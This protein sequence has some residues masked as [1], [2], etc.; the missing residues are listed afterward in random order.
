MAWLGKWKF[1]PLLFAAFPALSF[2][3]RNIGEVG[4]VDVVRPLAASLVMGLLIF[5]AMWLILRDIGR[6]ALA[7]SLVT[8]LALSYGH[9]YG[10]LKSIGLSG[11]YLVRHRYL[12]PAVLCVA[13]LGVLAASRIRSSRSWTG[14]MAAVAAV[15]LLGPALQI[16]GYYVPLGL[17]SLGIQARTGDC[18]LPPGSAKPDVYLIILDAYEREDVLRDV[19]GYDN[20][21]FLHEL[22]ALGFYVAPGSLS[23]YN[24]TRL[25][26]ASLL[27]LNYVQDFPDL[28]GTGPSLLW[29]MSKKISDSEL[30]HELECLG[31]RTVA[32][33]T[34]IIWTEWSDAD[35]FIQE[36]EDV[37]LLRPITR[38]ELLFANTTWLRAMLDAGEQGTEGGGT[39]R[40]DPRQEHRDRVLFVLDELA[41]VAELPSP[42]FVFA[43]IVSPHP[44]Y[45]FGA[46]GED[47]LQGQLETEPAEDTGDAYARQVAYLN[48]RVL[49]LLRAIL[50]DSETPP[51]IVLMGDHGRADETPET[52]LSIL[53]AYFLPEGVEGLYPTITPVNTFRLILDHIFGA[54][55]GLLP[56]RSYYSRGDTPYEFTPVP[57]T[58]SEETGLLIAP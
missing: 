5:G 39:P 49:E 25:S 24:R 35:T 18:S 13:V 51:V 9:L 50:R 38:A 12:L 7:A 47:I 46:Q 43:H 48:T 37:S 42:K 33:E 56:D 6:A 55:F 21:E 23:N 1:Y 40:L 36:E 2:F 28:F 30:R 58:W 27:N 11:T 32:F 57:N 15:A 17:R 53:N 20:S 31:Y 29:L 44:P 54:D 26:L 8:L 19:H 3:A 41:R 34:G 4:A 16:A 52:R 45:V 14:V 10:G 22:E